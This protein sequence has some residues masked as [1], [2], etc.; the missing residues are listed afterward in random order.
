MVRGWQLPGSSATA[1]TT[2][3]IR[4]PRT[5]DK[6]DLYQK[7]YGGKGEQGFDDRAA[8]ARGDRIQTKTHHIIKT[9]QIRAEALKAAGK[10]TSVYV[11]ANVSH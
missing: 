5:S 11:M 9:A 1:Y 3:V 2:A 10:D 7:A 6:R 8:H 4:L